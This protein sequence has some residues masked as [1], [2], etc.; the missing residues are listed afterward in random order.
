MRQK[1]KQAPQ[2]A[3][4]TVRDIRRATRRHF[5]AEEKIR[6]VLD[7]LRGEDCI[8]E[9]CRKEGIAQILYYR[10]SKKFPE[11][12]KKRFAGDTARETAS[13]EVKTLRTE[14]VTDTL[15][16]A[17]DCLAAFDDGQ[18][19]RLRQHIVNFQPDSEFRSRPFPDPQA[20]LP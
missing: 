1:G 14:D 8:T 11:A 9:L 10:W 16:L 20:C 17:L 15:Q 18:S 3:E 4:Q 7:G 6:I 19:T 5:S 2:S 13:D 12:S